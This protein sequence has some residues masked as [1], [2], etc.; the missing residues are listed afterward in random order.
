MRIVGVVAAAVGLWLGACDLNPHPLPPYGAGENSAS[1]GESD[2]S[3]PAANGTSGASSSGGGSSSGAFEG[4]EA[5]TSGS[6]SGGSTTSP[7]ADGAAPRETDAA[8]GDSGSSLDSAPDG[9]LDA[10]DA[11]PADAGLE[12]TD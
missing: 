4:A 5:G 3:V 6:S 8:A 11:A 9:A 2:A 10:G 1:G 12:P 7:A